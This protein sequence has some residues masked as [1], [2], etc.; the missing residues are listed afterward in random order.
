M[1]GEL[2]LAREYVLGQMLIRKARMN[3]DKEAVILGDRRCTFQELNNRVNRL[4]NGLKSLGIQQG[5]KVAVL[6]ENCMEMI[7]S[8]FAIAK[9]GCV[10]VPINYRLIPRE[11]AYQIDNS[12]SMALLFDRQYD[13]H[14]ASVHRELTKVR[15]WISTGETGEVT[16]LSYEG[17]MKEYPATEPLVL[18]KDE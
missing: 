13:G 4:A 18:I 17:I 2:D 15:H 14:I 1:L 6:F 3:P 16:S 12:D 5:D 10:V 7:E 11:M 8:I 9:L